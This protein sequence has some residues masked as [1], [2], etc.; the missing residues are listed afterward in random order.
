MVL[1]YYHTLALPNLQYQ[2]RTCGRQMD[3]QTMSVPGYPEG[4]LLKLNFVSSP[5]GTADGYRCRIRYSTVPYASTR[6][7]FATKREE[8]GIFFI[9]VHRGTPN[10]SNSF[11]RIGAGQQQQQGPQG[12]SEPLT[13]AGSNGTVINHGN[14][15]STTHF[16]NGTTVHTFTNGTRDEL[17]QFANR[18]NI[19]KLSYFLNRN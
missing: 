7:L 17:Q 11:P 10:T 2:G 9:L 18:I 19:I 8:F 3:G 15:T 6:Q 12:L 1:D 4:Y 14:G 13:A 16:A 5:W